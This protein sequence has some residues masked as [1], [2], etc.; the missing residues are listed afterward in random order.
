MNNNIVYNKILH[1]IFQVI[2][3]TY[4]VSP[5]FAWMDNFMMNPG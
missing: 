1:D 2:Q 3:D 4:F 5:I